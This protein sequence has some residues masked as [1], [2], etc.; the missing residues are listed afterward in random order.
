MKNVIL[1][2]LVITAIILGGCNKGGSPGE[3]RVKKITSGKGLT[4]EFT[5]SADN[6]IQST[7]NSDST[8]AD[9]TFTGNTITQHAADP[10]HGQSMNSTMHLDAHGYVD[11]TSAT[12]PTGGTY[13][14]LDQHDAD[15]YSL[16]SKEYMSGVLRRS[17]SSVVKDGNEVARTISDQESKPIATVYFEYFTDKANSLSSENF[18]MKFMGKDSKNLMKKFVQVLAK[19]DT[20]GTGTFTYTYDDKGRITSKTTH[21]GHGM[22]AD[23]ITVSYY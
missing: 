19:G 1:S 22:S 15:G 11:S 6:R 18:G 7:K 21:D 17:T 20:V 13:L 8:K 16:S 23:S 2:V 5:Y 9:F 12:D 3:A 4:T 10:V 14:K